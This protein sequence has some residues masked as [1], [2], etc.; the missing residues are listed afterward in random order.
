VS[1]L[2]TCL[3]PLLV[4]PISELNIVCL[5]DASN[6]V[7]ARGLGETSLNFPDSLVPGA[8]EAGALF[9]FSGYP[10][11]VI[12]RVGVSF[13][14]E[15]QACANVESEVGTATFEDVLSRSKA[16]W[17]ERLGRIQIDIPETPPKITELLYSSLYR[18]SLT[19]V[20]VSHFE[21]KF[22]RKC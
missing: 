2:V 20:S 21:S 13:I 19:P 6:G 17:N 7:V 15:A 9:S 5:I 3:C 4:S 12:I 14:S 16:L 10:T 8:I 11:Q 1:G 22:S 18:A